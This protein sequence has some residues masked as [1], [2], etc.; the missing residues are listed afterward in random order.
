MSYLKRI[1]RIL[2]GRIAK[3]LVFITSHLL[4]SYFAL[5]LLLVNGKALSLSQTINLFYIAFA[6]DSF[7]FIAK[8]IF[9]QNQCF[10]KLKNELDNHKFGEIKKED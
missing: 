3:L 9:T 4:F 5:L 7:L 2:G 1:V 8:Y 6:L 10:K